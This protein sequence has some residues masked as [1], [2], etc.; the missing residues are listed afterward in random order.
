RGDSSLVQLKIHSKKIPFTYERFF[1]QY[2]YIAKDYQHHV[3]L[4]SGRGGR[5]SIAAFGPETIFEGKNGELK[6]TNHQ[7]EQT[8]EGNP[9]HL[10]KDWLSKYDVEKRDEL[11][12]F[13]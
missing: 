2:R 10:L 13:Q 12:D 8:L 4:E 5:Y 6:I 1:R 9:L 11:P 3:L 7:E